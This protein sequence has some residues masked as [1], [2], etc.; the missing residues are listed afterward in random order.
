MSTTETERPSGDLTRPRSSHTT[1]DGKISPTTESHGDSARL[2]S[3]PVAIRNQ[4]DDEILGLGPVSSASPQADR[5]ASDAEND[6]DR[7]R[8]AQDQPKGNASDSPEQPAHLQAIFTANPELRQAW[9]DAIAYRESFATPE[10][11]RAATAAL[12]DLDHMDSLFFSNRAVDHAELARAV[13]ALNPA[14]FNSLAQAMAKIA[15]EGQRPASTPLWLPSSRDLLV[16]QGI[17]GIT[18]LTPHAWNES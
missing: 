8:S 11:A 16:E 6:A 3:H 12:A 9:Q 2:V 4:T 18:K 13:A 5:L 10:D 1:A 15:G 17:A 14:A 7:D